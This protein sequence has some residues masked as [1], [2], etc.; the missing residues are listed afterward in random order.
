M[1]SGLV[2]LFLAGDV[3]TGRGVDQILPHPGAAELREPSVTDARTYVGLAEA[4][5]GPIPRPV[6]FDWPWGDVP[7]LLDGF[8]PDVRLVN[9]ETSVT[10]GGA[11][12]E[13]KAVHYRMHPENLA[14]LAAIRPD[15]CALANNHVLDF[16]VP[17]LVETLDRLDAAGLRPVGAGP[18]AEAA[19]RPVCRDVAGRRVLIWS[20]ATPSSGVPPT[21]AATADR[22]GVAFLPEVSDTGAAEVID[23]IDRVAQAGDLVVV[24]IHWGSNWGYEVPDEHV[25]FAHRL[26][27][28]GVDVVHGHS[29]HHP[30][31]VE[32]YRNRLVLYGC[33]DL[34]DDYE[35]ISG[36]ED[37]RSDLRLLY[38]PML[39][40][41]SGELRT[42]RMAPLRVRRMR[43]Q[44]ASPADAR[45][46]CDTLNQIS[47]PHRAPVRLTP[48]GTLTIDPG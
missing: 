14:C 42:L 13:D 16:G 32:V 24:S 34:I 40:A 37:Y 6:G 35:G 44:R 43:L 28:A 39:D 2:R 1:G 10:S 22:P 18:D 47:E 36:Y 20:V 15:A 8:A 25:Q 38:L 5:N 41:D 48:D 9:L 11:H 21:W 27:D 29:S 3:M 4:V 30:R 23:R 46:L 31:P 12:A 17:G 7:R 19:W 33:G 26:V 45:W